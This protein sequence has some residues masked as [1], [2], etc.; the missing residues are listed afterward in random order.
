[1]ELLEDLKEAYTKAKNEWRLLD[2]KLLQRMINYVENSIEIKPN[3]HFQVKVGDG[4]KLV[5]VHKCSVL[6]L[7]GSENFSHEP[8]DSVTEDEYNEVRND[9]GFIIKTNSE[10][11][12][13]SIGHALCQSKPK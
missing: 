3:H 10:E 1:M 11:H 4:D 13:L 7:Q 8:G 5:S 6:I 2:A 12:A 9:I